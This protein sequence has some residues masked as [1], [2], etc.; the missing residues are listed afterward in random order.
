MLPQHLEA[1][2]ETMTVVRRLAGWRTYGEINEGE[3]WVLATTESISN[4]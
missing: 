3:V 4:S 1:V 2:L